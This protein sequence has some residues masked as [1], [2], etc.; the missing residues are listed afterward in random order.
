MSDSID[1][2]NT[3]KT[4]SLSD[5]NTTV[6]NSTKVISLNSPSNN[7]TNVKSISL[8]S[9]SNNNTNVK[10]I[11]LNSPSNNNT[12]VKSISLY[13]NDNNNSDIKNFNLKSELNE[14]TLNLNSDLNNT[15][16]KTISLND[17]V[18]PTDTQIINSDTIKSFSFYNNKNEIVYL[19]TI[20]D[21]L[22]LKQN[23]C[24][25]YKHKSKL[26]TTWAIIHN[27]IVDNNHI[28]LLLKKG[29]FSWIHKINLKYY[30]YFITPN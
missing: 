15:T 5:L 8:N 23:S 16:L 21:I 10:S 17:I 9:H 2:K 13:N 19:N 6:D 3:T 22:K 18:Q 11:S 29:K 24:I 12:N 25:R 27:I 4:I 20:S 1:N 30:N 7:N 28:V 14:S 26:K